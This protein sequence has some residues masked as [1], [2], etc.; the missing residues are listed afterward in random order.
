MY[1][2]LLVFIGVDL[3]FPLI[4]GIIKLYQTKASF[5]TFQLSPCLTSF[6][7]VIKFTMTTFFLDLQSKFFFFGLQ[8]TFFFFRSTIYIFLFQSTICIFLF[9]STIYIFLFRSRIY[10]FL[11]GLQ[12]SCF[13]GQQSTFFFSVYNLHFYFSV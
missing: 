5:P 12:P 10:I 1:I 13:F 2:K 7:I 6:F 11:F 8:S 4:F 9:W 3:N